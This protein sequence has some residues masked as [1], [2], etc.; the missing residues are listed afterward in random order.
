ME[1]DDRPCRFSSPPGWPG[2]GVDLPALYRTLDAAKRRGKAGYRRHH[3]EICGPARLAGSART[4][5]SDAKNLQFDVG[6]RELEA[7]LRFHQ[8]AADEGMIPRPPG[9]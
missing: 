2:P 7:V 9:V 8:F 6:P 5:I 4:A 3:R 1:G